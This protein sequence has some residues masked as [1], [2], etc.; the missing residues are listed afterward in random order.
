MARPG[1]HLVGKHCGR[2]QI[3]MWWLQLMWYIFLTCQRYVSY[4]ILQQSTM[5]WPAERSPGA[6]P[7]SSK[8]KKTDWNG[9][10][11][12]TGRDY[13]SVAKHFLTFLLYALLN[14]TQIVSFNQISPP[15]IENCWLKDQWPQLSEWRSK[16]GGTDNWAG[17]F[18]PPNKRAP[19]CHL[20][21]S[22]TRHPPP[23]AALTTSL[24]LFCQH[25]PQCGSVLDT[26]HMLY[27][28]TSTTA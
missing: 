23:P 5:L 15:C 13:I 16:G 4:N 20:P 8:Q 10:L 2:L 21:S 11:T 25:I 19:S 28:V 7:L 1:S 27:T 3:N 22:F 17:K 26:A 14:T 18:L 24:F 9:G 6:C 12:E